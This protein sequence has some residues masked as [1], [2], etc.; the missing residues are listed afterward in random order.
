MSRRAAAIVSATERLRD[1]SPGRRPRAIRPTQSQ[2]SRRAI[3]AAAAGLALGGCSFGGNAPAPLPV[4]N[5]RSYPNAVR[6]DLLVSASQVVPILGAECDGPTILDVRPLRD[7]RAGHIQTATHAWWQDTMER[8][9]LSYGATLK[10]DDD[11]GK[12]TR[13]QAVIDL[14][15]VRGALQV[16]VY[17]DH[18]SVE[19]ARVAWFLAFLGYQRV[20][21]LDGGYAGWFAEGLP[22]IEPPQ[23]IPA[24]LAPPERS[25]QPGYYLL[26]E[27]V[28]NRLADGNTVLLDIRTDAELRD[29]VDGTVRPGTIPGAL[30]WPWDQLLDPDRRLRPAADLTERARSLGLSPSQRVVLVGRF[31]TDCALSWLA[32][33]QIGFP[34]VPTYDGGWMEWSTRPDAPVAWL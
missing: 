21:V 7:Y 24:C 22:V 10:P 12:Q 5:A 23:R 27:Q 2:L 9:A 3:L 33:Q 15:G 8:N 28:L 11:A 1:P 16:I 13:R 34:D 29:T 31:A 26:Y 6:P 18:V 32:P 30:S 25:P 14:W 20:G 19:A 4:T 17:D